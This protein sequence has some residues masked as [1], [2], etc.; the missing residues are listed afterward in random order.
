MGF[1]IFAGFTGYDRYCALNYILGDEVTH[2]E[3]LNITKRIYI[4]RQAFN[5]RE[6][7]NAHE[8]LKF[9]PQL[10]KVLTEGANAGIET[11]VEE[12]GRKFYSAIGLNEDTGMPTREL[13][14]QIG[15]LDLV[16]RELGL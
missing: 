6:G 15:G 16:I 3:W 13:L 5:L 7:I 1:C 10:T 9:K 2:E 8:D 4:L 12:M 14:E 11:H